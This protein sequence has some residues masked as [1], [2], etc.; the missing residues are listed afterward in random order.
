MEAPSK[1]ARQGT[2]RSASQQLRAAFNDDPIVVHTRQSAPW[3]RPRAALALD[4]SVFSAAPNAPR[5][6]NICKWLLDEFKGL[7]YADDSQVKLLFARLWRPLL[8][9][10]PKIDPV[11][12]E[13]DPWSVTLADIQEAAG[14]RSAK[15][16][17]A[18][19]TRTNVLA[20]L[21]AVA[22]L[23]ERWDPMYEYDNW[24]AK[25]PIDAAFER[26]VL[27]DYRAGL[28]PEGTLFE[29][30]QH[31]ITGRQLNFRDQAQMQRSVDQLFSTVMTQLPVDR[32]RLWRDI[33]TWHESNPY[34]FNLGRLP[35]R[36]QGAAFQARL[37]NQLQNRRQRFPQFFPMRATSGISMVVFEETGH[38]KDLDNL[39]HEALPAILDVLRPPAADLPGWIANEADPATGAV[40]VPFVEVVSIPADKADIEPGTVVF[41]LSNGSRGSSWWHR[42]TEY[43]YENIDL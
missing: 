25:D 12:P 40:D 28:D 21:R 43:L 24:S 10:T 42:A 31:L 26:E 18:I 27:E 2:R 4:I 37:R 5:I 13:S 39:V 38:S 23:D 30:E 32:F 1:R 16:H 9:P 41:G 34:V 15:I 19:Q 33:V 17:A 35:E 11:V 3:P 20:N 14:E 36:G 22:Q 29:R 7:I 6:D 8:Q